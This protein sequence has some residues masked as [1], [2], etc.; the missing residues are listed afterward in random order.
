[1]QT[2]VINIE[3]A[4]DHIKSG[5]TVIIGGFS[6][7]G[8]PHGL[9]DTLSKSDVT[10]LTII[11]NDAS[12]GE[13][14][15]AKLF[16][17]KKVKKFI[18]SHIGQC[19]EVGRQMIAG[20]CNVELIPQGTFVER[21]RCSGYGLGGVLTRTGLGTVVE[22]GKRI[23]NVDGQDYLL[24]TPLHAD[25]ALI[26]AS[27]ADCFGNLY[28][29]GTSRNFNTVMA[30]AADTVIAEVNELCKIGEIE[31]ESIHTPG[32]FVDYIVIRKG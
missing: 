4:I 1:M 23:I 31:K 2:K 11:S 17:A 29:R 7:C 27:K 12:V 16:L 8:C 15:V 19:P 25:V 24:E 32:I 5:M 18:G 9:V 26:G 28:Y 13:K 14:D 20:E 21:I 10:D 22:D 6:C 30:T 3:N